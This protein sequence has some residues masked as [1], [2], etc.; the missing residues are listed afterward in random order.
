[1]SIRYKRR[2]KLRWVTRA[3]NLRNVAYYICYYCHYCHY[4]QCCF[5][6]IAVVVIV[7][8]IVIIIIII[9]IITV[10]ISGQKSF[11]VPLLIS[12]LALQAFIGIS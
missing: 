7:I 8:V 11:I 1:M 5:V 6:V 4:C 10:I 12:G 9:I 3:N 2:F